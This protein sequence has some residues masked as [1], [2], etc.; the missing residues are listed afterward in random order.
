MDSRYCAKIHN[1]LNTRLPP[2]ISNLIGDYCVIDEFDRDMLLFQLG[3]FYLTDPELGKIMSYKRRQALIN[4]YDDSL[5]P[6]TYQVCIKVYNAQNNHL[7]TITINEI[8]Q[9]DDGP[10]IEICR[11]YNCMNYSMVNAV[12]LYRSLR[13]RITSS[14][15]MPGFTDSEGHDWV[16]S[17]VWGYGATPQGVSV[18]VLR[19]CRMYLGH[20]E[21]LCLQSITLMSAPE[22][23]LPINTGCCF[24]LYFAFT[25]EL[26]PKIVRYADHVAGV[27]SSIMG[28]DHKNIKRQMIQCSIAF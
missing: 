1:M 14:K 21:L 10:N 20:N 12:S 8:A 4:E 6:D 19:I 18:S 17:D 16:A 5:P 2:V 23:F 27:I 25:E 9:P 26:L 24:Y 3:R 15:R 7:H 22:W 11:I 28:P 13:T